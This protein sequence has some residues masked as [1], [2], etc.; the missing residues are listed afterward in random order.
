MLGSATVKLKSIEIE[1]FR[2][3]RFCRLEL[4]PE[5][6]VLVGDNASGK[7]L[8]LDAIR[9]LLRPILRQLTSKVGLRASHDGV[10][11]KC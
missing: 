3:A 7:T 9:L 11:V 1:R 10:S 6:T 5:V 8:I 2:A 4:H